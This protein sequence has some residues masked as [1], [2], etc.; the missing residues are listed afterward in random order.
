MKVYGITS[1]LLPISMPHAFSSLLAVLSFIILGCSGQSQQHVSNKVVYTGQT[2]N[3]FNTDSVKTI[4]VLV[5]L[6]DN[7]YQG[8]V[9]VPSS[10]GNG[11]DPTT[12]LY[13]GAGYGVKSYFSHK[14]K[15]WKLLSAQSKSNPAILE[16]LLFKHKT[17]E[18]YLL[19]DAYDGQQIKQTIIDFFMASSGNKEIAVNNGI[20]TIFFGGSADLI[21]YVGHDGLMDFRISDTFKENHTRKRETIM[22]ACYSKRYFADHLKKTGAVP[23]LW[24]TGLMAPEAYTLHDAIHEWVN[25]KSAGDIN[26]AAAKAYAKYQKCS[27]NAAKK[28]LVTGW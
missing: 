10:I 16:R 5:A 13:W 6:C 14:S 7:K 17:K 25:N 28:L 3:S 18:V 2:N 27:I 23:L 15:D 20:K 9:P 24:T 11:Q 12:N 26:L 22:L 4:H 21:A 19:A 8:I 1:S